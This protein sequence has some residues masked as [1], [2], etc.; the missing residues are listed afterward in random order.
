MLSII[1]RAQSFANQIAIEDNFGKYTYQDLLQKSAQ[2]ACQLLDNQA[3]LQE[4]RIAFIATQTAEY[5]AMLWGIW[6]AGG[7][8][9]PLGASHPPPE[10]AYILA[11]TQAEIVLTTAPYFEFL[12]PICEAQNSQLISLENI[13]NS[14]IIKELPDI[15]KQRRA[16]IIYT[17]GTTGKPKGA[18]TTHQIIEA[19]ITTLVEAWEWQISD[20]I[21]EVLPLH[22]IHGI[23]NVMSCALWAGAKVKMLEKFVAETVWDLF[24]QAEFSLFMAVPTIYN[25]LITEWENFTPKKQALAKENLQKLRLMVSGSAALPISILEK[26]QQISGH[27]LLERY[28]MT[29]IGMAISNPLRGARQAG[30]VGLPLPNVQI[31]LVND[32]NEVIMENEIA[33]EIQVKSPSVFLEYWQKPEATAQTFQ[34]DWFKTGDVAMRDADGYYQILGRNSTDII[35]TGGYKVSALEIEETLRTHPQIAECAVVGLPDEDWGEKIAVAIILKQSDNLLTISTLRD[36]AKTQLAHY[37]IPTIMLI[38]NDLPRNAM[39]KVLKPEVKK[40]FVG[41]D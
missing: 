30:K 3:D 7:I 29:E 12:K 6:Q 13:S 11:D 38:I 40:M 39:G 41:G 1:A 16:L 37:K 8:A 27:I 14:L 25:R 9:V 22:H 15:S 24:F 31:R 34:A 20:Y 5:A 23:I 10:I 17:S 2:I 19:Q 21:L 32:D 28:G 18:V 33:G 36:W 4:K 35:K 26:W